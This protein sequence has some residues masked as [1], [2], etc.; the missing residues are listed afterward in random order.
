MLITGGSSQANHREGKESLIY[1]AY[2]DAGIF[3][4][5]VSIAC[6]RESARAPPAQEGEAKR[7]HNE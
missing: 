3:I 7:P 2:H 5:C 6:V 4:P 1:P